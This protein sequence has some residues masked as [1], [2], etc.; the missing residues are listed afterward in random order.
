M[1]ASAVNNVCYR[2]E[3]LLQIMK[4]RLQYYTCELQDL[5]KCSKYI[6][7]RGVDEFL[8]ADLDSISLY[9]NLLHQPIS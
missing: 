8:K 9:D 6:T 1:C 3:I 5:V 7:V 4:L 2:E